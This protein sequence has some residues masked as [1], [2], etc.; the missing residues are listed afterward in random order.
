MSANDLIN[1]WDQTILKWL[2]SGHFK[3][4]NIYLTQEMQ[5]D[6]TMNIKQNLMS[7]TRITHDKFHTKKLFIYFLIFFF[8]L[9][10]WKSCMIAFV[11][12]SEQIFLVI[13]G[14]LWALLIIF[15]TQ[16]SFFN[17]CK[18]CKKYENRLCPLPYE[19]AVEALI[20]PFGQNSGN[21]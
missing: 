10:S 16:V 4:C 5:N 18:K 13:T 6:W 17:F 19:E 20:R 1:L 3:F 9:L 8:F 11:F 14:M 12:A 21:L 7:H 2:F 15:F